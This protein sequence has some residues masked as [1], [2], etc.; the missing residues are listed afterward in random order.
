VP[1]NATLPVCF[2]V[3]VEG[4]PVD[5]AAERLPETVHDTT[6]E[7]HLEELQENKALVVRWQEAL[8]AST[9][10]LPPVLVKT[11]GKDEVDDDCLLG[12]LMAG[13]GLI[14]K[15]P[16]HGAHAWLMANHLAKVLLALGASLFVVEPM[17]DALLVVTCLHRS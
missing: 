6:S 9:L 16:V 8:V 11:F 17:L 14:Y 3:D 4:G 2:D 1:L 13:E 5:V 12:I 7:C 15:M 10:V